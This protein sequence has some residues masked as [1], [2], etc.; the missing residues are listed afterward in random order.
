MQ[1][2]PELVLV[3]CAVTKVLKVVYYEES[4]SPITTRLWL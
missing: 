3:E 2:R 4:Y 1:N